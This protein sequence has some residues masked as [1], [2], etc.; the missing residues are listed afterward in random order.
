MQVIEN[1]SDVTG[2]VTGVSPHPTLPD[3]SLLTVQLDD[4]APV[5][6]F[7]NLFDAARGK[8]I[9]VAVSRERAKQLGL[10]PGDSVVARI[11]R[12]GPT[13]VFADDSSVA[14]R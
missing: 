5:E 7:A 9:D 6:G 8:T 4:V 14:R 13:S 1:R 11:R 3:H 10:R 2:R 12:A